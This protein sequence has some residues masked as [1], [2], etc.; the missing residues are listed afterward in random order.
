MELVTWRVAVV[1]V[2]AG[3]V[4]KPMG[5]SNEQAFEAGKERYGLV[6]SYSLGD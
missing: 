1:N 3:G 5:Y 4:V 2:E 6:V